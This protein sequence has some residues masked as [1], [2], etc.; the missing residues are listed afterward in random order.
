MLLCA[1][2]L[3]ALV[4][5]LLVAAT[6]AAAPIGSQTRISQVGPDGNPAFDGLAPAVA[7]NQEANEYL[8]VWEADNTTDDEIEIYGRIVSANGGW[9]GSDF[10]IS[11]MGPDGNPSFDAFR[12]AVAYNS[13]TNEFLV[14]WHGNGDSANEFEVYG[15][16]LNA[17]GLEVGPNDFR[18]SDM[19]P[20]GRGAY[21]A[22]RPSL[23]YNSATNEYL[24]VWYGDESVD[25]EFEIYGQRLSA[26]GAEIG[27]ND[28]RVSDAGPEGDANF[29][30]FKPAIAFNQQA[31]DY[32][33]V[34]YGDDAINDELEIYGQ[35]LS[36]EGAEIGANDFR[37]SDMGPN[38]DIA[39][40]GHRPA[41]AYNQQANEYLVVWDGDDN[42]PP[43]ADN[44]VEI[45]GQ[46]LS[47]TGAE[48]GTNDFRIS[49]TGLDGD[50][51]FDAVRPVVAYS[52]ANEY[53]V[54]WYA[55]ETPRNQFEVYGQ[56]VN[57]A[58]VPVGENDFIISKLG[59]SKGN[60]ALD[61]QF[62]GL[63]YAGGPNE[64]LAVWSE[65]GTPPLV[66][67]E[68]EIF[69]RRTSGGSINRNATPGGN[70]R[71]KPRLKLRY[72]KRQRIARKGAVIVYATSDVAG[73]LLGR[74][75]LSRVR[76]FTSSRTLRIR[77]VRRSIE[78][79]R[80]YKLRFKLSK[81]ARR[82]VRRSI[83]R[84][85]RISVRIGVTLRDSAGN[86]TTV[87]ALIRAK[88]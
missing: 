69:G 77:A 30:A 35:R 43:L 38:G 79:N 6:V 4:L 62:P 39:F 3:A 63:A 78:T 84:H 7:Y 11:Q 23:S 70:R 66:D 20:D 42:T 10:R 36:A 54:A 82:A 65:D 2:P 51:R 59:G 71:R 5:G 60:A 80:R 88:R 83:S 40:E 85:K 25:N 21:D 27:A 1:I 52:Q 33:V 72:R 53:L 34:W 57:A 56:Y 29:D 58:G 55:N 76:S 44:E 15:Q 75:R 17:A 22:S 48:L 45:H 24:V 13:R 74:A 37:V 9:L 68:F 32:L 87:R 31:N 28:F 12:P 81:R 18:I 46:R 41:I 14:V 73:S 16:R 67:D 86:A 49:N 8:V 26:A 19:G 64:Y 50:S 47:A 61:A